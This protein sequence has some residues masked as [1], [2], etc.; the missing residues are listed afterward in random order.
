MNRQEAEQKLK[1]I[2]GFM[3]KQAGMEAGEEAVSEIANNFADR[4]INQDQSEQAQRMQKYM[5]D[6]RSQME[7]HAMAEWDLAKDAAYSA[8]IGGISGGIMG[9]GSAMIGNANYDN[10]VKNMRMESQSDARAQE[11]NL[12]QLRKQTAEQNAALENAKAQLP[13]LSVAR[14]DADAD[15]EAGQ[16]AQLAQLLQQAREQEA[17]EQRDAIRQQ[18]F[19]QTEDPTESLN[20]Q[21]AEAREQIAEERIKQANTEEII[22]ESADEDTKNA[23]EQYKRFAN[24]GN[25]NLL[26][27]IALRINK[28][29][30]GKVNIPMIEPDIDLN[31]TETYNVTPTEVTSQNTQ[32]NDDG[33]GADLANAEQEASYQQNVPEV[34]LQKN[35][36]SESTQKVPELTA[37]V[38]TEQ[39]KPKQQREMA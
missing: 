24:S 37:E 21:L 38:K 6:G 34:R 4:L 29:M 15:F 23:Y 22:N 17:A 14:N 10:S 1:E 5:A 39:N 13:Q 30:D 25:R 7:A 2:F 36:R 11:R 27:A 20:R 26:N 19:E 12:A 3:L 32:Q 18:R 31:H 33:W 8:L 35:A 28:A 9:G 16:N